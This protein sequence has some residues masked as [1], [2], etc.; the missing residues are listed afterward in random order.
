MES[1]T[2]VRRSHQVRVDAILQAACRVIATEGAHG[3]HM[4]RVAREAG[5]SKGLVHYYFS[6]R[7]ELLRQTIAYSDRQCEEQLA[8]E[9][10]GL[11]TARERVDRLLLSYVDNEAVFAENRALWNAAWGSLRLDPE[12]APDLIGAYRGIIDQVETLIRDGVADGSIVA[13][14]DPAETALSLTALA[15]GLSS[16][17][18]AEAVAAGEAARLIRRAIAAELDG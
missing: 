14:A 3:V 10:A 5:V 15:E 6:T 8:E 12:L 18:D 4:E 17:Y 9:L 13:I 1:G 7:T 16:L 2:R 11:Q